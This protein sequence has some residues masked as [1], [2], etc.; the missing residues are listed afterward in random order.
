MAAIAPDPTESA[1]PGWLG[2][3]VE[4]WEPGTG[5]PIEDREPATG[6][7]IATVRGLDAGR[8]RAGRGGGEGGP[9]G[10]GRDELPGAG[11]HPAPRGRDLR[12]EPRRVRRRGPSARPA[13]RTARC[14][15]SRTSPTSEILN[16]ATLPSQ[17]Y[18][19]LDADRRSRAGCRWS[20]A[21][22]SGVIGA[23]TPWNSPSVSWGCASSRRRSRS[24]TPSSSSRTRRRRSSAARCSRR[25]SARRAC[26][27]ASSRSSSAARTSARRSSPTRTS[28]SCRS[29]GRRPSAGGSVSWPAGML[30]KVSLELGGNNAFIVLDDADLDAAAAAGAFSAFQFQGQ[31]CFAAGRHLVHESLAE[32]YIDALTEKAKRLR[33][34]RPVS[35]RTSSSVRSS[36]RS[37]SPASTTS[38][39][40]R[41]TA[42]P[43]IRE[44]GTH[45]GLFYR[46][47]V[48]TDGHDGHAG[49]DRRDLRPGRADHGLRHRRGGARAGQRRAATAWSASIYT[50]SIVARPGDRRPDARPAWS[51]STTARSTTR[52]SSRS[53]GWATVRQR[54]PIRRRGEPRHVHRVAV[55]HGARRAT[56]IPVLSASDVASITDVARLAGVSTATV[57]RVVSAAPYA[58]Q[59]GDARARPRCRTG[60]RLRPERPG[61]RPAQEPRPGRRGRRPRHHRPVLLGGRPRRRGRGD[62]RRLPGHHLQLGPQRRARERR[63]SGCSGRCARRRSSSPAAGSTTRRSTPRCASTSRRCGATARRSSTCRR[64]PTARPEVGVDNAAGIAS[65]GRRARPRSGH[66]QIAFL[67]GPTSL[68]VARAAARRLSPRS[69]RGRPPVRRAARS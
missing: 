21:S 51:T 61:P 69:G 49:V 52:R 59:P 25:S 62:A 46:P 68:Y 53:A 4:T 67:A 17:P 12:G 57:S 5:A 8:R 27:R 34:R 41:S 20:G 7:L 16:A 37:R 9:A 1:A 39:S 56:D 33:T 28:R 31:V 50:R 44:G 3:F 26:P 38:S 23:I 63:T 54:Q 13:P 30:K 47:T 40:A 42:G 2:S 43:R 55:G 10:L 64:T 32:P 11:P 6:R 24:A 48:L 18:G 15:T 66:R 36:T 14:T 19:S 58:G 29:P 35:A 22:R 45:E 60:A 65:D